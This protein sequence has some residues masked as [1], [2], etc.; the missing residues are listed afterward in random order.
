M[1]YEKRGVEE[2]IKAMRDSDGESYYEVP[3]YRV[4]LGVRNFDELGTVLRLL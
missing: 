4:E 3:T 2:C 1:A